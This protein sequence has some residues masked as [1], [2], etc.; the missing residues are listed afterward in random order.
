MQ[1]FNWRTSVSAFAVLL[2]LTTTSCVTP[3]RA[4]QGVPLNSPPVTATEPDATAKAAVQTAYGKLPLS[5]EAN[6]GQSDAQVKFLS[7]G[8]GYSLF[9][10]PTEAV[11][12]LQPPGGKGIREKAIE[13]DQ[14]EEAP[15]SANPQSPIN[16][17][18]SATGGREP[19]RDGLRCGRITGTGQLRGWPGFGEVAHEH[20]HLCQGEI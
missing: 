12:T 7:R 11:L 18:A 6:Q 10:T 14:G 16:C 9:L 19:T 20:P 8:N 17:V 2:G 3:G 1:S 15:S 13:K 4:P 5:F